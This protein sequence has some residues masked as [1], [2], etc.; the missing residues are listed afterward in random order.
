M[1]ILCRSFGRCYSVQVNLEFQAGADPCPKARFHHK[2]VVIMKAFL[3]GINSSVLTYVDKK[4]ELLAPEPE[5]PF[6]I[7]SFSYLCRRYSESKS[8]YT[9]NEPA[10]ATVI[11]TG[12]LSPLA[13]SAMALK[14]RPSASGVHQQ[15]VEGH[16]R[17]TSYRKTLL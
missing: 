10:L 7:C 13:I 8:P 15:T 2:V 4:A 3:E 12:W 5:M 9:F 11:T 14:A 16:Q 17:A 6:F 1:A